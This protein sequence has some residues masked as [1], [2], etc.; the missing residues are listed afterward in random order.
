MNK[1]YDKKIKRLQEKVEYEN[2]LSDLKGQLSK[3]KGFYSKLVILMVIILNTA[4]TIGALYSFTKTGVEPV[5]I[6]TT[7]FGWTTTELWLLAKVKQ[8]KMKLGTEKG[9]DPLAAGG[10][11]GEDKEDSISDNIIHQQEQD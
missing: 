3:K 1:Y 9:E 4:F 6:T 5:A 10:T 2:K 8:H 11:H 7:W